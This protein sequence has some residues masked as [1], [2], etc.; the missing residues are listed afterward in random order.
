MDTTIQNTAMSDAQKTEHIKAVVLAE[1]QRLRQRHP[2]L[3]K[4]DLIG[5]LILA[6]SLLGMIGA[7]ALYY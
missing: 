4:Q 3:L 1:G 2:I 6:G 7:A 5:S